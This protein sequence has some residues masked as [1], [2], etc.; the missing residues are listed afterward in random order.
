MGKKKLVIVFSGYNDRAVY[1]F[2]RTL[3][4]HNVFYAVIAR[5]VNDS[6][7]GGPGCLNS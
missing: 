6:V 4:V 1:A 7:R 5:D 3:E 2:I